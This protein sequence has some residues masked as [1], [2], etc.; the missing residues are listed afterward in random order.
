MNKNTVAALFK[1]SRPS[2]LALTPACILIGVATSYAET[3]Q[4]FWLASALVLLGSLAAHISA[5]AFNEYL[6]F[7][8]GLDFNTQRTPFSGGSGALVET[9]EAHNNVLYLAWATLAIT[10]LVG[11]YFVSLHGAAL[12]PIGIAG[13]A[14]IITYTQWINR[15]PVL[16]LI[17]PGLSFGPLMV[18]GTHLA[19]TGEYSWLALIASLVPFFLTNNLLLLNQ[20]PDIKADAEAGRH[21]LPIAYGWKHSVT[22]YGCFVAAAALAIIT[23]ISSETF[24]AWS[25][26]ALLPMLAGVAAYKGAREHEDDVKGLLA[27]LPLNVLAAVITPLVFGASL[28]FIN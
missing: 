4:V 8:S 17:A 28:F 10:V 2:F 7:K 15:S 27:Y 18:I 13:V 21:H 16:C 20:L 1:S 9:P 3:G 26:A 12:L 25:S 23:G 19:L 22:V 24:N 5:N 14:I 11:L 6:D